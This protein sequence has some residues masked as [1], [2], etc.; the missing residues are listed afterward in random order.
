M[1]KAFHSDGFFAIRKFC[2]EFPV[3]V[4]K[5]LQ[6][7]HRFLSFRSVRDLSCRHRRLRIKVRSTPPGFE[8]Q[9]LRINALTPIIADVP[10]QIKPFSLE[11]IAAMTPYV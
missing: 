10:I 7:F 5:F 8:R 3:D 1:S 6:R 2:R 9:P 4:I 11:W